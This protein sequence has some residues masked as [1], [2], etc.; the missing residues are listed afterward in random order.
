MQKNYLK[1]KTGGETRVNSFN[2]I[3]RKS[4]DKMTTLGTI[5]M[6]SLLAVFSF[7]PR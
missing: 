2:F 1:K 6:W 4:E 3:F 5:Q 7:F